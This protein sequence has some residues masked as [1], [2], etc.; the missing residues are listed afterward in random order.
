MTK[1]IAFLACPET[2]PGTPRRRPDAFEHDL[3]AVT[4]ASGDRVDERTQPGGV[5]TA[6]GT[7]QRAGPHLDDQATGPGDGGSGHG[8]PV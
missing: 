5:E 7:G 2:L 3:G 6:T 1:R 8:I 4:V